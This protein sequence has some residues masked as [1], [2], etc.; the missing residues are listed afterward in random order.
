MQVRRCCPHTIMW[1]RLVC[2]WGKEFVLSIP[3]PLFLLF[4]RKF[5]VGVGLFNHLL[6]NVLEPF[7]RRD[8]SLA[9]RSTI[10]RSLVEI[11]RFLRIGSYLLQRNHR[12]LEEPRLRIRTNRPMLGLTAFLRKHGRLMTMKTEFVVE[13]L[14]LGRLL[15]ID[16]SQDVLWPFWR[17]NTVPRF[18][19][20]K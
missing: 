8:D 18:R 2:Q 17:P 10:G 19:T 20:A 9:Q 6:G 4:C 11:L 16:L 12:Y 3:I 5:V 14:T 1:P 13:F 15:G 7:P